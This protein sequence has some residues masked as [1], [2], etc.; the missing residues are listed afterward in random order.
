MTREPGVF[1]G[2]DVAHGRG[3][4]VGHSLGQI[5]AYSVDAWLRGVQWSRTLV[6][7][8][9]AT[10]IALRVAAHGAELCRAEMPEKDVEERL[11][12]YVRSSRTYGCHGTQRGKRCCAVMFVWLWSL[13]ARVQRNGG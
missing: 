7:P 9:N 5:A 12:S 2:G 6:N 3:T 4:A 10:V 13:P 8:F 11:G 1:A